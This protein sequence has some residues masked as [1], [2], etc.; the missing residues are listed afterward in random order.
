MEFD[1]TKL[2]FMIP[3]LLLAVI[4]HELGH[5]I[6]AYRLGD[7][8]PKLAGRLTFNPI[9]HID[10]FG[11]IIL[12][13]ILIIFNSPILFGW[14]KP[15]PINPFNF[16]KLGYRKGIAITS[17]AGVSMNMVFAFIFGFLFQL[18]SNE[19][20][21]SSI[22]S[23]LGTGFIKSVIMPLLIFFQYSVSINVIL[24]IFNLLPIPPLDGWRF[25]TSLL[26]IHLEQKIQPIEQYGM[27]ILIV[28]L[29][30][31]ALNYILIPPYIFL[32]KLLLG[33]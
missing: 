13:A 29:M 2:I 11:S 33:F 9:P 31:G 5:G 17:L 3:A 28:L 22:A 26:P 23:I 12:P 30:V 14:A 20:V 7:P 18:F 21:L 1:I 16:K 27:I 10:P 19:A 4:V 8:T 15:V 24:A 6:I 32:T 25:I